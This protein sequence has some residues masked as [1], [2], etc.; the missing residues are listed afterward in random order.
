M[1]N[2]LLT[3]NNGMSVRYSPKTCQLAVQTCH[4]DYTFSSTNPYVQ[5]SAFGRSFKLQFPS[6]KRIHIEEINS[7]IGKSVRAVYSNFYANGKKLPFAID[8]IVSLNNND[9]FISFE[10]D[11]INCENDSIE[12]VV[13]PQAVCFDDNDG[14]AYT[15][16]P[17]LQGALI[18]SKWHNTFMLYSGGRYYQRDCTMPWW[19]QRFGGGGY[20]A[21]AQ[22]PWDGGFELKHSPSKKT[23]IAAA[24]YPSLRTMQ[25]RRKCKFLFGDTLDY[26]EMCHIYREFVIESGKFVSLKE[27]AAKNPK[28]LN[29]IGVPLISDYLF[30]SIDESS[31]RYGSDADVFCISAYDRVKQLKFLN[32]N[33]IKRACIHFDG[34]NRF[35]Y[36]NGHPDIFPPNESIGGIDGIKFLI[37]ECHKMNYTLNFHDQYRDYYFN[38]PSFN[39]QYAIEDSENNLPKFSQNFGGNQSY[40]CMHNIL[41][42]IKRNY[43]LFENSGIAPD[44]VHLGS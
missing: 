1:D 17:S 6:A 14:S 13:W 42:F 7:T 23:R 3:N 38:S 44:G 26:N 5:V 8:T 31:L 16:V 40:L 27:K 20:I 12:K 2:Y 39:A 25:Y 18:P 34:C 24:W 37:S 33:G 11:V 9:N 21:I 19:G 35:G 32:E 41:P 43:K 22:T 4:S 15:V 10:F 28:L 29:Y 36:D 30:V